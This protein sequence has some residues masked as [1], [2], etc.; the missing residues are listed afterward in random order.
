ML[1]EFLGGVGMQSTQVLAP[2]GVLLK[3]SFITKNPRT[4]EQLI[5]SWPWPEVCVLVRCGDLD[6]ATVL[7]P[8]CRQ[9][10]RV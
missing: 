4:R 7:F 5:C 10:Q 9:L 1:A 3:K 8:N 2:R 6:P